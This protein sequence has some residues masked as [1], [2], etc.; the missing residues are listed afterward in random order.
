MCFFYFVKKFCPYCIFFK[1]VFTLVLPYPNIPPMSPF[2]FFFLICATRQRCFI[3]MEKC[4]S[5]TFPPQCSLQKRSGDLLLWVGVSATA[6]SHNP[7]T[8]AL[9]CTA[10]YLKAHLN[11]AWHLHECISTETV[12][13]IIP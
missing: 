2:L 11:A 8:A 9:V 6:P 4:L 3:L 13:Q 12:V 7:P 10:L 1:S 5:V